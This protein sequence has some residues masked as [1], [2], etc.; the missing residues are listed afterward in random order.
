MAGERDTQVPKSRVGDTCREGK[1][2]EKVTG[3]DQVGRQMKVSCSG[4]LQ[5]QRQSLK[6]M[7][8]GETCPSQLQQ[9]LLKCRLEAAD[10]S[11]QK[12]PIVH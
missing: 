12:A 6:K 5:K 10:L 4:F 3:R 11:S 9:P 8:G 1:E 2:S 7:F